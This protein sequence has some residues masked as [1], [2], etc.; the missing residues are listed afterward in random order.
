MT[1]SSHAFARSD[2][3][4]AQLLSATLGETLGSASITKRT[5]LGTGTHPK[6]LVEIE[7]SEG[8]RR[9]LFVKYGGSVDLDPGGTR[10]GVLYEAQVYRDLLPLLDIRTVHYYGQ[11]DPTD[12]LP[13]LVLDGLPDA[14]RV[15][16]V[17]G[18]RA[19]IAAAGWLGSF[20]A[21]TTSMTECR[22]LSWVERW[23]R[24]LLEKW[25]DPDSASPAHP[26][27]REVLSYLVEH[28]IPDLLDEGH[29]IIHGEFYPKN[30]LFHNEEVYPIDWESAAVAP[31]EFD[32]AMLID[33]WP[34][35]IREAAR[36]EYAG[37]RWRRSATE[38]SR[39]RLRIAEMIL[40]ARWL[41]TV[42][43]TRDT[44]NRRLPLLLE[45]RQQV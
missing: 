28:A 13:V 27:Y 2:E 44:A 26:K 4:L 45:L 29:T 18:G 7:A 30:I 34:S 9:H 11:V 38:A 3:G 12:R 15:K 41:R 1:V 42:N 20:H 43:L 5:A 24:S 32:L 19:M 39:R 23:P 16:K 10:T 37:M 31:S 40:H 8:Q 22:H 25:C 6:E 21:Q 35:E 36:D 33:G 14:L 17:P